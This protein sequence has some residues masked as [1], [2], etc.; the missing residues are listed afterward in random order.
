MRRVTD[1]QPVPREQGELLTRRPVT[2]A[3]SAQ[4]LKPMDHNGLADPYA[5]LHLLP[6]ASKVRHPA[7]GSA[8]PHSEP[9]RP[10]AQADSHPRWEGL[11]AERQGL[12]TQPAPPVLRADGL[13]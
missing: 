12:P 11:R 9:R 3:V 13:G 8:R 2:L 4:G 6:G 5:K 10:W 7:H 1:G